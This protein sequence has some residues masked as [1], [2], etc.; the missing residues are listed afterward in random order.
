MAEQGSAPN[1]NALAN[2]QGDLRGQGLSPFT[3][4]ETKARAMTYHSTLTHADRSIDPLRE[5]VAGSEFRC[6]V[7]R[8]HGRVL[9]EVLGVLPFEEFDA[10]LSVRLTAE[11]AVCGGL[12]VF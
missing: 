3:S 7:G 6:H 2:T 1:L 9:A 8:G 5:E 4:Q 12:L 11:V 10:V